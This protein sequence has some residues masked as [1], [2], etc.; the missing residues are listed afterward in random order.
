VSKF[1][2]N[3]QPVAELQSITGDCR[4]SGGTVHNRLAPGFELK[5]K[6]WQHMVKNYHIPS[7]KQNISTNIDRDGNNIR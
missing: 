1:R 4:N 5:D 6:D 2:A 3:S 7:L